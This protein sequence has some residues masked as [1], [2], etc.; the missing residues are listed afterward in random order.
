MLLLFQ[1]IVLIET[2][3]YE[4]N[5]ASLDS[6]PLL[7]WFHE[8]KYGSSVSGIY[9]AIDPYAKPFFTPQLCSQP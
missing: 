1:C 6:R 4:A 7:S 3:H 9:S 8:S 5:W 2:I